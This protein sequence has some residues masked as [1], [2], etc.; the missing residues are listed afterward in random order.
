MQARSIDHRLNRRT[1]LQAT[2]AAALL[3]LPVTSFARPQAT[4]ATIDDLGSEVV[5]LWPGKAPGTKARVPVLQVTD[6]SKDPGRP[7]RWLRSVGDPALVVYRPA[8]PNGGAVLVI[9]GGGYAVEA[10]DHEG[11]RQAAWLAANGITAFVLA[12]R[13]PSEGWEN[14][15]LVPLQDAQRAMRV[16]RSRAADFGVDP[17]RVGA[18]GFSA[19]G[20][21]AGSLLTRSTQQVYDPVDAADALSAT[22]LFAG[23]MYPVISM[24]PGI[25]HA[26]SRAGLIGEQADAAAT[27][28]ASVEANVGPDTPPAFI[29]HANDDTVVPVANATRMYDAM[30][31][32]DRPVA[33]HIFEHG[34]HGFATSLPVSEPASVWPELFLA[35]AREHGLY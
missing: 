8:R 24:E 14:P 27:R 18:L 1:L 21:L 7:N 9:P 3:A 33:L 6:D 10:W 4:P 15:S 19:G 22:P 13:L 23:L 35:F 2:G 16:I 20:H 25:T 32:A 17:E 12:Y 28:A 5:H 34:G 31:E 26:G 30:R 11:A 29:V